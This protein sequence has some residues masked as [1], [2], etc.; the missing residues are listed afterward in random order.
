[1]R[2]GAQRCRLYLLISSKHR[3]R[4]REQMQEEEDARDRGEEMD[5]HRW[6]IHRRLRLVSYRWTD[7]GETRE[8]GVHANTCYEQQVRT[9]SPPSTPL[10]AASFLLSFFETQHPSDRTGR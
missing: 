7:T 4:P 9:S 5:C 1:M 6:V 10:H 2:R 3:R 8:D